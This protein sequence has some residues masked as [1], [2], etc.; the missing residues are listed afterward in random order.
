MNA[1]M[2]MG[3]GSDE[4]SDA[5]GDPEQRATVLDP[6]PMASSRDT[7]K[8]VRMSAS[9]PPKRRSAVSLYNAAFSIA[10]MFSST[11]RRPASVAAAFFASSGTSDFARATSSL[12]SYS[13]Y[14]QKKYIL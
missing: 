4:G 11:T 9:H 10:V 12:R 6:H 13:L 2:A 5:F 8:L 7:S 3:K 1:A 14:V